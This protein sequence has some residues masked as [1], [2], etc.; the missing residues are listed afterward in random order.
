MHKTR[1]VLSVV[2]I[3]LVIPAAFAL[4]FASSLHLKYAAP[5]ERRHQYLSAPGDA[6]PAVRAEVLVALRAFQNGYV[7]R[8][9]KELNSFMQ[10]LFAEND[11]VLLMGT[12][13]GEWVRGY[14][15]VGR[16]IKADWLYWGEFRFAID[17]CIVS[18]DGDVA[19]ISS[20]GEVT[21]PSMVRPVRFSAVLRRRGHDWLFRQLQF[22][23]DD[24]DPRTSDLFHL[25][26]HLK[27]VRL[28]LQRS[29]HGAAIPAELTQN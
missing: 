12:N 17:D 20:V 22:Q 28:L 8:D 15:A 4:G 7:K 26:T 3:A 9:P 5:N 2:A 27:L 29:R 14:D 21:E 24:R 13:G 11:D 1:I 19:W 10:R 25:S 16:F 23:W 18:S 6:P